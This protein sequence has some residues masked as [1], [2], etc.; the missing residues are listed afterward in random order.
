MFPVPMMPIFMRSHSWGV[1]DGEAVK[2]SHIETI[3]FEPATSGKASADSAS[4]GHAVASALTRSSHFDPRAVPSTPVHGGQSSMEGV[5][6]VVRAIPAGTARWRRRGADPKG[7][8]LH[9]WSGRCRRAPFPGR[10][11]RASGRARPGRPA[12]GRRLHRLEGLDGAVANT[13]SWWPSRVRFPARRCPRPP[14]PPMVRPRR[15]PLDGS[16]QGNVPEPWPAGWAQGYA[17]RTTRPAVR[18]QCIRP[19][20]SCKLS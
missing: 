7:S 12:A 6:A 2:S 13:P 1:G 14:R 9:R 8:G 19:W 4:D 10:P 16:A 18:S 17:R 5:G 20:G 11:R 15:P 3:H